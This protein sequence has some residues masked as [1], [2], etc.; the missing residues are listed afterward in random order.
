MP[1]CWSQVLKGLPEPSSGSGALAL[2]CELSPQEWAA[3]VHDGSQK[4]FL[5]MEGWW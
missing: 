2:A 5:W 4:N 3:T 1:V